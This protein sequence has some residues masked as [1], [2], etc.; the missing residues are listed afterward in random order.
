LPS[1][2]VEQVQKAEVAEPRGDIP[3]LEEAGSA[4]DADIPMVEQADGDIPQA[5]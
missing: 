2:Q 3:Q 5:D 1:I 4:A